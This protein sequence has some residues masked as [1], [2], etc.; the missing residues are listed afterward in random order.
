MERQH[1][2][3][4]ANIGGRSL[5]P[6]S[7]ASM[8]A[9]AHRWG[10]WFIEL[11]DWP[12]DDVPADDPFRAKLHMDRIVASQRAAPRRP[13]RVCWFDADMLIRDDT[14]SVFEHVSPGRFGGVANLQSAT[15]GLAEYQAWW[16]MAVADIAET[17]TVPLD[18]DTY[19]NGGLMVFD[20]PEHAS[21]WQLARRGIDAG[22][23]F[24]GR[25][26]V[27][28]M[29][30]QTAVNVAARMTTDMTIMPATWNRVGEHVWQ[31]PAGKLMDAYGFHF[32][33]YL[34]FRGAANKLKRAGEVQWRTA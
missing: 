14:P 4:T 1:L 32:A 24:P 23:R 26:R 18:L 13:A 33:N 17:S 15:T 19:V 27:N 29:Y 5:H 3:V 34:G 7:R 16:L 9:A 12:L 21:V 20:W 11:A 2:V 28:P 22:R 31:W 30:E 10:A 25:E 8:E 6:E